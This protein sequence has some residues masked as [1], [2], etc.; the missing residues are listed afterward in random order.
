MKR[1]ILAIAL[2]LTGS[3]ASAQCTPDPLYTDSVFGVWPDT[4][5]NFAPGILGQFYS[6]TLNLIVPSNAA[7]IPADPPYPNF[8]LDSIQ[9][10]NVSGLPPGLAINCNSQTAAAC[11][12]LPE[13]L[14]CGLIEG[15]PTAAGVFDMALTVRAWSTITI[16]VPI[17]VSQ[18]ITFDGYEIE[19]SEINT[20][21]NTPALAGLSNVRNIPN[22]FSTRTSIEFLAGR[23]GAARVRVFDLVGEEVWNQSLQT[24][25]GANK[26][27]FEAADLPAGV[28]LYKIESGSTTYTGRMALQR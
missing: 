18:E 8:P 7:D 4:T 19:I 13:Q 26:V 6:D 23:A 27:N 3:W 14:G 21:V 25:V 28:Y 15:T 22:P 16:V 11:T 20:A 1:T 5:E 9:L 10:L 17:P 24:K 12:Y 2:S